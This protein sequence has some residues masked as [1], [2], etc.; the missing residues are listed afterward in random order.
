MSDGK[1]S[2]GA[3]WRQWDLHFHTPSSYDYKAKSASD[4][5]LLD[6]LVDNGISVV[7]ITDH[8]T[9]DVNR[10]SNLQSL[11]RSK[12][13]KVLPGIEFLSSTVGKD[14]VHF[15]GI[16][17]ENCKIQF[18]WDQL[19]SRT[20][21]SRIEGSGAKIEEVY[22]DLI[23]TADIIHELG[24]VVTIHAG[25][26]SNSLENVTHAVPHSAAQKVDIAKVVDFFELGKV[27]DIEKYRNHS[28]G[29]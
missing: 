14:P 20:N 15:I 7:A 17:D 25:E 18:V 8:G 13:I 27:S 11:G 12:Q 9:I 6:G 28:Q 22:C 10:I 3:E 23:P 24:G 4:A 21:L 2:R 26:K 16:F 1:Y 5:D 29:T 19:R